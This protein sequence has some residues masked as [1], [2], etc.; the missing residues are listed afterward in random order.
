M[1]KIDKSKF[2]KEQWKIIREDRRNAKKLK[3]QQET[4]KIPVQPKDVSYATNIAFVL[5]NG[6]SRKSINPEELRRFGKIYGCNALY[7][8]FSPDYLIS[9]DVK[10]ILEINK[11]GYQKHNQVWT[12]PNKSYNMMKGF[13]FFNP[14]KG[15][16]SGPTALWLASQHNYSKIYILGFDYKGLGDGKKFNNVYAD[17]PN[18]KKSHDGATFFG[19]WLR[20]TKTVID[21]HRKITYIRV[22]EPDNYK[23]EELSKLD[24]F[25]NLEISNFKKIF[26]LS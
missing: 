15:W 11:T 17:T 8:S 25:K 10:M 7:R 2:S 26:E 6:T 20:Q 23:P 4:P 19:N 9:V 1:A 24:N 22:I 18:Y 13:N 12:N 3:H 16:S 5:G 14:S 21:T